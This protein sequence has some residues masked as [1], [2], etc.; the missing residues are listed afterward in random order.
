MREL[1]M[2][3]LNQSETVQTDIAPMS[4]FERYLSIWVFLCILVGIF[5]SKLL[6]GLFKTIGKIELAKVNLPVGL[7]I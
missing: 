4:V 6:P 1:P 3:N 7:L 5:L 2:K